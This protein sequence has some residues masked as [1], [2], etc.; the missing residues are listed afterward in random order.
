MVSRHDHIVVWHA[1]FIVIAC[2]SKQTNIL[3]FVVI[4]IVEVCIANGIANCHDIDVT[5]TKI[6]INFR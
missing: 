5:H 2:V 3:G 6:V 4:R 1:I